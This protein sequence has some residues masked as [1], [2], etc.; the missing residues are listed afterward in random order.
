MKN[1]TTLY[2]FVVDQSGSMVGM[3]QQAIAGFNTQLEKIQDLEKKMPDQKFLCSL[4]F[5]NSEVHDLLKNEPVKEIE[6]LNYNNYRPGGS[7]ALLDAVGGSID[8]IEKQF[9]AELQNDEMSVVM[10]IIT[11]GYENASRYFTYHMVAQK[12][13]GLDETGKWTFSYL[14]ADFD[15]IHTSKMMNIRKENVMNFRKKQYGSMMHDLS[16]SIGVYAEEKQ[17]GNLKRDILDIFE[18]K[19]RRND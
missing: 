10:V 14:G 12:I 15:A 8:R 5:F 13:V 1:K 7:T 11:D 17:K 19:D 3:E 2:H 16:D 9:T 6:L 18:K 4:T